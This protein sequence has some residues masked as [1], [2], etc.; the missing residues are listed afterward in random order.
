MGSD[1]RSRQSQRK[2]LKRRFLSPTGFRG[3]RHGACIVV[4]VMLLGAGTFPLY[5]GTTTAARIVS[6]AFDRG[7]FGRATGYYFTP[8]VSMQVDQ[9]GVLDDGVGIDG[10]VSPHDIG[11]FRAADAFP[12]VTMTIPSGTPGTSIDGSRFLPS[13]PVTLT[14]GVQYYI[15]ANGFAIDEYFYGD[16]VGYAPQV[17]WNGYT[18]AASDSIFSA[19]TLHGGG[20]GNLGPNFRFTVVPEPTTA[21]LAAIACIATLLRRRRPHARARTISS[22]RIARVSGD[23]GTNPYPACILAAALVILTVVSTASANPVAFSETDGGDLSNFPSPLRTFTLDVGVNTVSGTFGTTSTLDFDSFAFIVPSG[24]SVTA[25]NI[26]LADAVGDMAYAEWRLRLDSV[27]Y[28]GGLLFDTLVPDS[29]GSDAI[30]FFAL[31]LAPGTYDM[32]HKSY[33]YNGSASTASYTFSLNVV[34]EPATVG[35]IA[36][37][38]VG[39]VRRRSCK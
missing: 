6:F 19:T 24:M 4:I 18:D 34:P 14:G 15:V 33:T 10:F 5:A 9:L 35:L 20:F 22:R 13:T 17:T 39:L 29:P 26:A 16:G 8:T 25:G 31:P 38:A 37:P 23:P 12:L 21:S 30:V 27:V 2:R 1:H 28:E 32:W 11:I 3:A 36:L 7:N